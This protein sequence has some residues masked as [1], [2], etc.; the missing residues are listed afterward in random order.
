M[1]ITRNGLELHCY[2]PGDGALSFSWVDI[3][4]GN[5]VPGNVTPSLARKFLKSRDG[6]GRRDY[7]VVTING[8]VRLAP[9]VKR[10]SEDTIRVTWYMSTLCKN[11]TDVHIEVA[12]GPGPVTFYQLKAWTIDEDG[13]KVEFKHISS[14]MAI[15]FFLNHQ[16]LY[17]ELGLA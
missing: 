1:P 9:P 7:H 17:K 6:L 8:E 13:T 11:Y 15:V 5:V 2:A 4:E 10:V 12:D 16:Q 14:L 3:R